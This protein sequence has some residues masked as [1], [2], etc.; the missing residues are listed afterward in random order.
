[1]WPRTPDRRHP[2]AAPTHSTA[3]SSGKANTEQAGPHPLD[4]NS[5]RVWRQLDIG[6]Q[7]GPPQNL[8]EV[9]LRVGQV[10]HLA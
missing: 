9:L 10:S 8:Q 1:M 5:A 6:V 2:R 4:G 7:V 3:V